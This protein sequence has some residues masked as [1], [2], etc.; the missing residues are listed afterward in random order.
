LKS[1][2]I[3]L[4]AAPA[5]IYAAGPFLIFSA[6]AAFTD[7]ATL[8]LAQKYL[9]SQDYLGHRAA[10]TRQL[11]GIVP[12]AHQVEILNGRAS[13]QQTVQMGCGPQLPGVLYYMWGDPSVNPAAELADATASIA[14]AAAIVKASGCHQFG[15]LAE[16]PF[17][18]SSPCAANLAGNLYQN[19]DWGTVGVPGHY[20]KLD[21]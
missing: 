20:G 5:A 9:S 19:I 14:R 10:L 8:P 21:D 1:L 7:P 3:V 13:L 11:K 2:L 6:D 4:L 17:W 15:L 18:G 16:R 12:A